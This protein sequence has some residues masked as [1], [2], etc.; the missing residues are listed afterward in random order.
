MI[1]APPER[2]T[3]KGV[4]LVFSLMAT[5]TAFPVDGFLKAETRTP[6]GGV[7]GTETFTYPGRTNL[8]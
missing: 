4:A 5:T 8:L 7:P 3:G 1:D 6:A 2:K